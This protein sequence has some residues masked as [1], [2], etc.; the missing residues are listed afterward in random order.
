[1]NDE[2]PAAKKR[3]R[4]SSKTAKPAATQVKQL[5][6]AAAAAPATASGMQPSASPGFTL[7]RIP[8]SVRWRDLD[9]FNHVNNSKFLSYLEEARLR[10]MIGFVF[11]E[12][13]A[14]TCLTLGG[15]F[16]HYPNLRV[17]I[18]HGGGGFPFLLGRLM[19]GAAHK[20]DVVVKSKKPMASYLKHIFFDGC[21]Y[22]ATA[23]R[24]LLE[25]VGEDN[26]VF[27]T[28]YPGNSDMRPTLIKSLGLSAGATDKLVSGNAERLLGIKSR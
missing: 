21:V 6:A 20:P 12:T 11:D 2:K 18:S 13:Y 22:D 15:V 3:T 4:R 9:A 27:G 26:V 23:L 1:M 10:W 19:E 8:L 5:D 14:V 7:V 25:R 24:F 28:N 16:D 17:A